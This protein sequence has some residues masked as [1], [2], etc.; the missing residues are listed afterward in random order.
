MSTTGVRLDGDLQQAGLR[1][2]RASEGHRGRRR[3]AGSGLSLRIVVASALLAAIVASLV[4]LHLA[5][6][7]WFEVRTPSMGETAPVG[8]LV[9][10]RAVRADQLHVGDV[11]TFRPPTAQ[12]FTYTHRIAA[13]EP[14]G[15]I[16]T[17]GDANGSEDAWT[18]RPDAVVGRAV[19]VL[20]G[21]GWLL[22]A[23][24]WLVVGAL[25]VQF[26]AG[27][28]RGGERG[29]ERGRAQRGAEQRL[30]VRTVGGAVVVAVV[31]AVL[32]PFVGM[33]LVETTSGTHPTAT[34]IST[35][36]LPVRVQAE[37]GGAATL[38]SGQSAVIRL[39]EHA[40]GAVHITGALDLGVVGWIVLLAAC[41]LPLGIAT[42]IGT[43]RSDA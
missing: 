38:T 34:V 25:V 29:S 24:P 9:V 33:E 42:A 3:A 23:L 8:T 1:R 11:I 14:D 19:L 32:R 2:R 12:G 40:H 41:L 39:A 13:I 43:K 26:V 10:D 35:G 21:V 37:H 4:G 22:R 7:R 27:W 18:L 31:G 17:R 36:L 5:G 6:I 28:F 20:P 30:A 15:G 16:R